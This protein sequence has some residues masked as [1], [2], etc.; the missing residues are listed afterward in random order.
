MFI[1]PSVINVNSFNTFWESTP[2]SMRGAWNMADLG[3][4]QAKCYRDVDIIVLRDFVREDERNLMVNLAQSC[5]GFFSAGPTWSRH[6]LDRIEQVMEVEPTYRQEGR[7][8]EVIGNV[9]RDMW[10][11]GARRSTQ[12]ALE[13]RFMTPAPAPKLSENSGIF[14]SKWILFLN[15]DYRGGEIFF[16][17]RHM[18]V[19]PIAGTIVRWPAGIPHGLATAHEGYQFTLSGRSV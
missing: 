17:T 13:R 5:E 6:E 7:L 2:D 18:V 11:L 3:M 4:G 19:V 8:H 9:A 16:P 1:L 10:H 12:V 14:A 15:D